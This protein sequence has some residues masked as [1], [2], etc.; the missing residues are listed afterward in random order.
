[1]V[2]F[3]MS[4]L[5]AMMHPCRSYAIQQPDGTTIQYQS[6]NFDEEKDVTRIYRLDES[7]GRW[8]LDSVEHKIES[9]GY[10]KWIMRRYRESADGVD[11]EVSTTE[12]LGRECNRKNGKPERLS[13][14]EYKK[15]DK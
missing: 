1:M 10:D 6:V 8:K 12:A 13:L 9:R 14:E 15:L 2:L 5:Q 3:F 7:S 11:V 4:T